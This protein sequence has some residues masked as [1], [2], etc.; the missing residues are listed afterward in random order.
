MVSF[1]VLELLP[2]DLRRIG[3]VD[4]SERVTVQYVV[5]AGVLERKT[6]NWDVSPW[7]EDGADDFSVR[8]LVEK[9]GPILSDGGTLLGAATGRSLIGFAI[10]RPDL[11]PGVSE[12]V[13]LYVDQ[14]ARRRGVAGALLDEVERLARLAGARSLYASATPSGSAVGFYLRKGFVLASPPNAKLAALEPEDIQMEKLLYCGRSQCRS[15][16]RCG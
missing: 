8:G 4:R 7:P 2:G 5:Q 1:E 16:S 13:A 12:L 10:H 14:R 15:T 11:S 6:V 9:W 3:E